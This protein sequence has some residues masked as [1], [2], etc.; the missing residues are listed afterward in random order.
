MGIGSKDA[1]LNV[2]PLTSASAW[3][4]T[5]CD[6]QRRVFVHLL[7]PHPKS[8]EERMNSRGVDLKR[9]D[10]DWDIRRRSRELDLL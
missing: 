2:L 9:N 8:W 4:C 3:F 6:T 5:T 10:S 1:R 7:T